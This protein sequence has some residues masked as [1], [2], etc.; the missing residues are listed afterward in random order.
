MRRIGIIAVLS[1][2]V[3]ALSLAGCG[4]NTQTSASDEP[5]NTDKS[6]ASGEDPQRDE[7]C[8]HVNL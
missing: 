2:L 5:K 7:R 4:Q 1:M 6:E 3:M 8:A